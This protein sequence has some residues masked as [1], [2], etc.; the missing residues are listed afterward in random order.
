LWICFRL[1]RVEI[2]VGPTPSTHASSRKQ[3][4]P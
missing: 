3:G 2:N 1:K 4:Q